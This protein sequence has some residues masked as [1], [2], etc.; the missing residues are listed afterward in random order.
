MNRRLFLSVVASSGVA[1]SA[2]S[3]DSFTLQTGRW[4][5]DG[6][7]GN[8]RFGL[9]TPD[10]DPVPESEMWAMAPAGVSIH[11][12]RVRN[13]RGNPRAFADPPFIDEAIE[14]LLNVGARAIL[15][16]Y[17]SS[18]YM[19]GAAAE[20]DVRARLEERSKGIE[21]VNTCQAAL[22]AF[23]HL[24]VSRL[25]LF[26]PPWFSERANEQGRDYFTG[27]GF[28]I[29]R[30]RR[31]EPAR[32]FTEVTPAEV[33]TFVTSNTPRSAEV[34]FVSGN[35]LRSVGAIQALEERLRRPVLTANQVLLWYALRLTRLNNRVR[36]YGTIFDGP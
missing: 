34:V 1:V 5:R 28:T 30:C 33:F 6:L 9:L 22:A 32:E 19:L 15:S 35:G 2:D 13:A 21:I 8:S 3:F 20:K 14:E 11:V 10:F 7:G 17:T 25:A 16:A 26:H 12:A 24:N 18:S 4:R 29:E 31:I 36:D 23:R 27:Y